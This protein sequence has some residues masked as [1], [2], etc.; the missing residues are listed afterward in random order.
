MAIALHIGTAARF[1]PLTI[2]RR[3][4]KRVARRF[5][6]GDSRSEVEAGQSASSGRDDPSVAE[7]R[8]RSAASRPAARGTSGRRGRARSRR[9]RARRRN[10]APPSQEADLGERNIATGAAA[11]RWSASRPP[12]GRRRPPPEGRSR[13]TSKQEPD[14]GQPETEADRTGPRAPPYAVR[15]TPASPVNPPVP[16]NPP[17]LLRSAAVRVRPR[18]APIQPGATGALAPAWRVS[19]GRRG[20]RVVEGARLE[21]VYAG[22]R[23][24]GSNPAPS[25]IIL[26]SSCPILSR[27]T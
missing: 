6:A 26:V 2:R 9:D 3:G 27:S 25:A 21:S 7:G 23:I 5:S 11:P 24:A 13:R 16:Q 22:N 10:P 1:L 19:A 12:P 15:R 8:S 18:R 4:A 14:H 17:C 20:G